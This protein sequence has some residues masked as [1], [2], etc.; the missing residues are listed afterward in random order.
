M[1]QQLKAGKEVVVS[2]GSVASPHLLLLSGVGDREH[3]ERVP[4]LFPFSSSS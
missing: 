3:L 1:I 2:A 4:C